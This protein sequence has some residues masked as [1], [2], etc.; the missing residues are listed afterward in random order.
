MIN[1]VESKLDEINKTLSKENF[2]KNKDLV[3]KTIKQKKTFERI[4][5]SYKTSINEIL[6]LK[7]LFSLATQEKNEEIIEDCTQKLKRFL[8]SLKKM[9]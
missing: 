1:K 3:K 4:L 7:D 9:K 2:W 6:N 8:I 5:N